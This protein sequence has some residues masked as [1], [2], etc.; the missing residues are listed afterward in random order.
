MF[1]APPMGSDLD[2]LLPEVAAESA[3]E[4]LDGALVACTLDE[5]DC[6]HRPQCH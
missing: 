3:R 5:H 6:P 2:A 4:G 1:V